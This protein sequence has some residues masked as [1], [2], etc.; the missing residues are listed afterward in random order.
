MINGHA[1]G[2]VSRSNTCIAR[3]TAALE[4]VKEGEQ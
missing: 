1:T 3:V 4:A 2:V